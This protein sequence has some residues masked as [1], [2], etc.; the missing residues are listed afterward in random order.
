VEVINAHSC[1]VLISDLR[2]SP[3]HLAWGASVW[4]QVTA[5]NIKGDSVISLA[6]NGAII[7]T[8]P[9]EP[10]TLVDVPAV[11]NAIQV[12]LEWT[13]PSENGGSA[14]IDYNVLYGEQTGT[15]NNEIGGITTTTYTVI[16]LTTGTLYK[17][18]I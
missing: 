1:S 14:V 7:L 17:F 13:A 12:G 9:N 10:T 4:A 5:T 8:V 11:T 15:Y 6:G 2:I 18:K 16:G 3:Y